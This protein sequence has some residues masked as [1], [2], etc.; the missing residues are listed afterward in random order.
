MNLSDATEYT[1]HCLRRTS[2]TLLVD[3]GADITCLKCHGGGWKS[4]SVAEGYIQESINN[5]QDTAK[6]ILQPNT[7]ET[8]LNNI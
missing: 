6:K 1:C 3:T 7:T 2:A 5:K 4:S 8:I